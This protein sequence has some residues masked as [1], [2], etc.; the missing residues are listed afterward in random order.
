M[1]RILATRYQK[2]D[3]VLLHFKND[4]STLE[5][6]HSVVHVCKGVPVF[7]P[8]DSAITSKSRPNFNFR[9]MY[10]MYP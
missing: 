3:M 6:A 10:S 4:T 2:S 1:L 7:L 8:Y 9:A 5:F